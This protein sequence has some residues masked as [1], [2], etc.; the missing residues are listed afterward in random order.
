MVLMTD[1]H[2]AYP[3][4]DTMNSVQKVLVTGSGGFIGAKLCD[5]LIA[6]GKHVCG[7]TRARCEEPK[8]A[9]DRTPS[10][11]ASHGSSRFKT[12]E[13]GNIGEGADWTEALEGVDAVVHLAA[14][15][16]ILR[17]FAL[18]LLAEFRKINTQGTLTL[19]EAAARAGVKRFVF[20]SSVGA[21]GDS[22]SEA[23]LTEETPPRPTTPYGL[24]KWEAEQALQEVESRTGIE[25]VI[26]RPPLLY[27]PRVKGNFLR[28]VQLI[29]R[30]VPLPLGGLRNRRSFLGLSNI[31]DLI[32][33][34]L[35]HPEAAGKTFLA[36]DGDDVSTP[37]L[38]RRI[39]KALGKSAR[40]LPLP[41][42]LLRFGGAIT[43]KSEDVRRLCGSLQIDSSRVRRVLGWT[44]PSTMQEELTRTAEWRS[45]LQ[46]QHAPG[47]KEIG[48]A[49]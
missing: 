2:R 6:R 5:E 35:E 13:V 36:S 29:E 9:L 4:K 17:E 39:A 26:I 19:A 20:L 12:V 41:E 18:D 27:G 42:W 22:S 43:G 49:A 7:A 15:A 16:H 28:F 33:C 30:G 40:L 31:V 3:G 14:R 48:R 38:I 11:H 45:A 1:S 21:S 10:N 47:G 46:D 32:C 34:C 24:S 25:V 8:G 44:P 37:E 23:P